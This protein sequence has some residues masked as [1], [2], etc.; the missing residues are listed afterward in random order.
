[1][2]QLINITITS[3]GPD[4]GPYD[5]FLVDNLNN[6]SAGPT[7]IPKSL[8][9]SP[10][11]TFIV[12]DNIVKVRLQSVNAG[13]PYV[14]F[15]VPPP[16]PTTTTT[17]VVPLPTCAC[18]Y[19]KAIEG[20]L[21]FWTD[22]DGVDQE[23]IYAAIQPGYCALL[24][25]LISDD[26][27]AII[28]GGTL[29]C[30]NGVCPTPPPCKCMTVTNTTNIDTTI[31]YF[32]CDGV[33]VSEIPLYGSQTNS[34]CGSNVSSIAHIEVFYGDDC[35]PIGPG[36]SQV[37]AT[38]SNCTNNCNCITFTSNTNAGDVVS[39]F[40]CNL[41]YHTYTMG[42]YQTFSVCG[43]NPVSPTEK[44][45][46]S[47]GG[48]CVFDGEAEGCICTT[49]TSST[50]T[51]TT[52]A[53]PCKCY[54]V[55]GILDS[56][57][58]LTYINCEGLSTPLTIP[59]STILVPTVA[60]FCAQQ[61]TIVIL[62]NTNIPIDNGLCLYGTPCFATTTTTTI[63]PA[64]ISYTLTYVPNST[65]T[66]VFQYTDCDGV[67]L[68]SEFSSGFLIRCALEGS[69]I[70]LDG[71]GTIVANGP[72]GPTTTTTSTT[73]VAP[74]ACAQFSLAGGTGDGRTF[75]YI[76]CGQT[77][78]ISVIIPGGDEISDCITLPYF[79]AGATNTG[80]CP[81]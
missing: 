50:T 56:P 36:G 33:F 67:I 3:S 35:Q 53:P 48:S 41:A 79:A 70:L 1:M 19:V 80:I 74:P 21:V 42:D 22:C 66:V 9:L 2:S 64:C 12:N 30:V 81:I 5:L 54:T 25:T 51:T 57:T 4:L 7:S 13:C 59:Q 61:G 6:V 65:G 8:L 75:N 37:C 10:G 15:N 44:I 17:T 24:G 40:D 27:D 76:P 32:D 26:I 43:S 29:A 49:T 18:Y 73:T 16:P 23:G 14:E 71:N 69:V 34:F 46:I 77:Q 47:I 39:W 38:I 11:Y 68:V 60:N 62:P 58:V 55:N 78:E 52:T 28:Y 45:T 31:N 63:A 20:S 72:C